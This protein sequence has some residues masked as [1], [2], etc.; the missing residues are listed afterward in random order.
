VIHTYSKASGYTWDYSVFTTGTDTTNGANYSATG[1][2]IATAKDDWVVA[3]TA[4]NTDLGTLS[5]QTIGGMS[6][7][8]TTVSV[9]T[10]GNTDGSGLVTTGNDSR[11]LVIDAQIT[12]GS[13]AAAPTV[14][15]TNA[16]S[17]SGSSIW[18]RLRQIAPTIPPILVMQTRRAY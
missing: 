18:L 5:A 2:A 8:T 11:L 14:T 4:I 7:D 12:A 3:A 16:S 1:G 17:S 13:S 10:T 15:Y 9:R 6:G